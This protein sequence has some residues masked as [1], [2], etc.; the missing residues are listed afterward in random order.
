MKT[1]LDKG[2]ISVE[3]VLEIIYTESNGHVTSCE[4]WRFYV[5]AGA[6]LHPQFLALQ[7]QFGTMQ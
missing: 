5:G 6:Q 7:P 1:T 3:D 4:Q 2:L